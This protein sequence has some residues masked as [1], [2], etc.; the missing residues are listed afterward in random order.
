MHF[1]LEEVCIAYP[2]YGILQS[3][4]RT[5]QRVRSMPQGIMHPRRGCRAKAIL[6]AI[7]SPGATPPC[8]RSAETDY[9]ASSNGKASNE[10]CLHHA[11][12]YKVIAKQLL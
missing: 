3:Y 2:K 8:L 4:L 11:M 5:F 6:G 12:A 9:G 1:W 10:A 7:P